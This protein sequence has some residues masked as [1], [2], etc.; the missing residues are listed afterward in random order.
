MDRTNKDEVQKAVL[1]DLEDAKIPDEKAVKIFAKFM[2][3]YVKQLEQD[4]FN[5]PR[6]SHNGS[7]LD[8]CYWARDPSGP[9]EGEMLPFMGFALKYFGGNWMTNWIGSFYDKNGD[10]LDR[11]TPIVN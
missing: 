2:G 11:F 9:M 6:R 5:Q 4:V 1:K 3:N 10:L 8:I 7:R